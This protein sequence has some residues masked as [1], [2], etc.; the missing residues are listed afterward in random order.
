LPFDPVTSSVEWVTSGA[1]AGARNLRILPVCPGPAAGP[2]GGFIRRDCSTGD[3]SRSV[4]TEDVPDT[5]PRYIYTCKTETRNNN[6][7]GLMHEI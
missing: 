1:L 3:L 4:D 6:N 2:G 7:D 5:M